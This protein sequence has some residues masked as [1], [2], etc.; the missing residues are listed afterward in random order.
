MKRV[1]RPSRPAADWLLIL[2]LGLFFMVFVAL[3]L[4]LLAFISLHTDA[5]MQHIGGHQYVRFFA[6]GFNRGVLW[7]TL[8]LGLVTTL[9]CIVL[10][11]PIA[12]LYLAA[13]AR[14]RRVLL[15]CILLPLL[16]SSVVRTFAWVVILG[17]EGL[18]NRLLF[19][20]GWAT[21]PLKLLYTPTAVVLALAQI[22]LPLMVLP[23]VTAL[24]AIDA[25][26]AEASHAL[27]ASAW[28]TW[29]RVVLPLSVPGLLSGTLLVFTGAVSA[30][31]VQTLVGGGQ[32]MYMPFYIYQQAIQSQD[33]PFAAAVAMILLVGILLMVTLLNY[34]GRKA[35]GFVHG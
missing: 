10:G 1:T 8:G 16:T 33:Y 34:F 19:A 32:L 21:T 14:W 27:G 23:L 28:R 7:S 20:L 29:W 30:F 31:V 2:P 12:W 24:G 9:A 17:N 22:E 18:V 13:G 25:R 6:D 35:S 5:G 3:P 4:L 11:Y 15:M 26:L